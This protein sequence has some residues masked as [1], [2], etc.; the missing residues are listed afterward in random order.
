MREGV[1][2]SWCGEETLR[3]VVVHDE[4][5]QSVSGECRPD[6]LLLST[7]QYRVLRLRSRRHSAAPFL[8]PVQHSSVSLDQALQ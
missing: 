2:Q 3:D 8:L 7:K 4:A 6:A 5:T 1:S